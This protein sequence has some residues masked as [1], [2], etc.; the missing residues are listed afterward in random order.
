MIDNCFQTMTPNINEP[1][2]LSFCTEQTKE[3]R[4]A[5]FVE[6]AVC[7]PLPL[8]RVLPFPRVLP[9]FPVF[10]HIT[11]C[12]TPLPRVLPYFHVFYLY[13]F[14]VSSQH[15]ISNLFRVVAH[16]EVGCNGWLCCGCGY[17]GCHNTGYFGPSWHICH[18]H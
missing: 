3:R 17:N 8:P 5:A 7:L 12:F 10:Y 13:H 18:R 15:P 16:S 2:F 11:M 4:L 6:I 1:I 9:H 14:H